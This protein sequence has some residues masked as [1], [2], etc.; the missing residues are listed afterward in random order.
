MRVFRWLLSAVFFLWVILFF[1]Q[2]GLHFG[3]HEETRSSKARVDFDGAATASFHAPPSSSPQ[4]AGNED[5]K[6]IVH[7]GPNPLHNK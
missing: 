3:V 7:T 1:S 5:D 6:R 4:F 2:L